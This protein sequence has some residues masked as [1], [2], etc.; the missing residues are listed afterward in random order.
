ML[1]TITTMK[2]VIDGSRGFTLIELIIV[3]AIIGILATISVIGFGRYQSETRDARRASSANVITEALE[4]YYDNNG[5]YPGCGELLLGTVTKD[6]LKGVDSK[7]LIAPQAPSGTVNSIKCTSAGNVLTVQGTDFFEYQGDGSPDCS[8]TGS[9][10]QYTLKYK[11]ETDGKIIS[12][13]SR[14]NT[15]IATSGNITDLSASSNSFSTI[16]LTWQ[17]IQ[18]ASSYTV[19][20]SND[21][22]FSTNVV[23]ANVTNVNYTASGLSPGGTY[24]YRV[25][26]IGAI[27]TGEAIGWSNVAHATT[28][29]LSTPV[30]TATSDSDSQ[31]TVTWPDIQ[32]ETS[33]TLQYTTNLSSWT[34]PTSLTLPAGTTSKAVTDLAAGTQYNFRL[35][36]YATGDTSDWSAT[37]TAA[38]DVP[39][40]T[41]LT[42]TTNSSTQI[43]AS[44][45]SVSV[46]TS[47]TLQYS[48]S[49]TFSS[50][51]TTVSSI[52]ST[53]RAVTGLSQGTT[54]YFRV[55]SAIGSVVGTSS[56][57]TANATTTIDAPAAYSVSGSND[58]A[59]VYATSNAV[60]PAGTSGYYYW[61]VNG[62]GW[63][64]GP[65]YRSV[66]YTPGFG[67]TI[68]LSVN[69][70]CYK[71]SVYSS[72]K[73]GNN[74]VSWTRP[75]MNPYLTAGADEC[76]GYCGRVINAYWNNICGSGVTI[77]MSQ[78]SYRDSTT[79]GVTSSYSTH[80]EGGS[81]PGVYTQYDIYLSC[82]SA[83]AGINVISAYHCTGCS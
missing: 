3:I 31:I 58:G 6:T 43:T 50:G 44:W 54:Y 8:G 39:A 1:A 25:K 71:G 72:Y 24:Y 37:K 15:S 42:A 4:K 70:R 51:V 21:A 45:S 12:I 38:T 73:A 67:Q 75:G 32:Y 78:L 9:C 60:C 59:S 52:S 13:K 66:G 46:A 17:Q 5:E 27:G 28:R 63:V 26:P 11:D 35:Q 23:D 62:S 49:S 7:A 14:R 82:A 64:A 20:Q 76:S 80:W 65:S 40:P 47:Y 68:T 18:N 56:S 79:L 33:Y 10:L 55:Y 81:S 74:S 57:S 53:S 2:R 41:T 29:S 77:N 48:T 83:S 22:G 16:D 36:A 34:S 19:E 69:S 61:Y 30:I